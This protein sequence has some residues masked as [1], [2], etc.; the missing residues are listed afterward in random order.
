MEDQNQRNRVVLIFDI[1]GA[2][3]SHD[4][5]DQ[6]TMILIYNKINR[7]RKV[8]SQNIFFEG[9]NILDWGRMTKICETE[10]T[11]HSRLTCSN[12]YSDLQIRDFNEYKSLVETNPKDLIYVDHQTEEICKIALRKDGF[13]LSKVKDKTENLCITAVLQN[14][15]VLEII[16]NQTQDIC[17]AALLRDIK[18]RVFRFVKD[19]Y[20]IVCSLAVYRDPDNFKLVKKQS[21]NLCLLAI[22]RKPVMIDHVENVTKKMCILAASLVVEIL[23]KVQNQ[24]IDLCKEVM[25]RDPSKITE[26]KNENLRLEMEEYILKKR[27]RRRINFDGQKKVE[28]L[29]TFLRKRFYGKS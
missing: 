27:P 1:D 16:E 14:P 7:G 12:K 17:L 21:K 8:Y 23:S 2:E 20:P 15:A 22:S 18:G 10:L 5:G 19:Q 3:V 11:Q 25:R 29:I 26:I 6:C 4:F 9:V 24:H 13:M 28:E